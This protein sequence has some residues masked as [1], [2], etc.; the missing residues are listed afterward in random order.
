MPSS[1]QT[2]VALQVVDGSLLYS[3][4][5]SVQTTHKAMENGA[6]QASTFSSQEVSIFKSLSS[7][8]KGQDREAQEEF[9]V[10]DELV[11]EL[12]DQ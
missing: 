7:I 11:T 10:H 1:P 4:P 12:K 8:S 5:K 6:E 9:E 2:H 3:M